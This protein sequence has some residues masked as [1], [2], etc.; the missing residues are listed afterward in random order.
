MAPPLSLPGTHLVSENQVS[1]LKQIM[2]VENSLYKEWA[3]KWIKD[4]KENKM[5]RWDEVWGLVKH[6]ETVVYEL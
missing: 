1:C 4:E 3:W 5:T 6:N 2:N